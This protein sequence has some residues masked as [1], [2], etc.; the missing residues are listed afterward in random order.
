LIGFPSSSFGSFGQWP[1]KS[2]LM[3]I[4]RKMGKVCPTAS[5]DNICST[6]L[7]KIKILMPFVLV[8]HPVIGRCVMQLGL[9]FLYVPGSELRISKEL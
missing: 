5:G 6:V 9:E 1:Q 8:F 7:Y 2:C 4:G 3:G